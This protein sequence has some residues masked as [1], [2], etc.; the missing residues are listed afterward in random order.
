MT[1]C[2]IVKNLKQAR[3]DAGLTQ[4]EVSKLIPCHQ[5]TISK[6]EKG[7]RPIYASELVR[8]AE[9]YNK[10]LNYFLK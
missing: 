5:S 1:D 3:I 7:L 2:H 6:K 4:T 9:I 8:F 10:T